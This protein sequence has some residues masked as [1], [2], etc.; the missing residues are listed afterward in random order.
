[1]RESERFEETGD[2][3]RQ[4][5]KKL[6]E[7]CGEKGRLWERSDVVIK[8]GYEREEMSSE[9]KVMGGREEKNP[10]MIEV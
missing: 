7:R 1:M 4:R 2:V 9:R 8:E 10:L 6:L 3:E 5:E